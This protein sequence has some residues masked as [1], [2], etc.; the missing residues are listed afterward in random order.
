VDRGQIASTLVNVFSV[1][2]A[3]GVAT[4]VVLIITNPGGPTH[5][6]LILSPG[7]LSAMGDF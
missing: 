7:G 2:A 4:G 5:T 6:G 3:A 1:V